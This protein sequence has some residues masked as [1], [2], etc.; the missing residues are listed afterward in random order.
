MKARLALCLLAMIG[1]AP[2]S[3]AGSPD[4]GNPGTPDSPGNPGDAGNVGDAGDAG[5]SDGS[6][7]PGTGDDPP[8]FTNGVSTLSGAADAGY[9]DGARGKARF[10][11]PVNVAVAPDG[12]VYVADFDNSKIRIVDPANGTTSTSIALQGFQRPFGMASAGDGTL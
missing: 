6:G 10:A 2:P 7:D 5:G 11:N 3:T 8:P 4:A 1:C 12:M 9:V